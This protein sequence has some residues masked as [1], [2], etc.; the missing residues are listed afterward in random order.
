MNVL[1]E[2]SRHSE[3]EVYAEVK[4]IFRKQPVKPENLSPLQE[5]VRDVRAFISSRVFP[6]LDQFDR[7]ENEEV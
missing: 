2:S 7:P 1:M 5:R 6:Y 3:N 4:G